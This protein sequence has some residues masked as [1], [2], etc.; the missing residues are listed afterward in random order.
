MNMQTHQF[1]D[2]AAF[3]FVIAQAYTINPRAYETKFPELPWNELVFVDTSA[4]EWTPGIVTFISSTAGAA[5]WYSGGAK[6]VPKADVTMDKV[7][8][9]VHMAAIGYGYDLEE[10]GQAQLLGMNLGTRKATAARRAYNEF[11]WNVTQVGDAA[12]GLNGLINQSGVTAGTAPADGTGSVTTWFDAGGN[13]TKTPAQILR[14]FNSVVI[15]T[16][17][18]SN[19]VEMIDTVLLPFEVLAWLGVTPISDTNSETILSYIMRNNFYTQQTGRQLTIRGVLGLDT[20]GAGSTR[21]MVGYANRE[22]VVSLHLPMP[23]RFLPVYQDGPTNFEVPG[24]F[25]TGGVDV[26]RPGAFRYLDGI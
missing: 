7:Q 8:N 12:K 22:D 6:D 23:H 11:M 3:N 26:Q 25:R 18:G 21:R 20:A 19:T 2:A 16:Y 5:R 24:I 13:P 9:A 1:N 4:P 10:V 17:I 15:G 14:D